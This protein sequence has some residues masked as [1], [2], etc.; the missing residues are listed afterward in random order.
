MR[1]P[2][3]SLCGGRRAQEHMINSVSTY[4]LALGQDAGQRVCMD[5]RGHALETPSAG[6]LT[7]TSKPVTSSSHYS[8]LLQKWVISVPGGVAWGSEKQNVF[9]CK[10]LLF[11]SYLSHPTR[12]M[13]FFFFNHAL[14]A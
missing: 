2:E 7:N 6:S 13:I 9:L 10:S 5:L 11:P 1:S 3:T 4:C 8:V 12:R 14:L